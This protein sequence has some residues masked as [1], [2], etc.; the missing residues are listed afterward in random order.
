MRRLAL[1]V[2][3]LPA[4]VLVVFQ[5]CTTREIVAVR[6]GGMG[7]QPATATVY[8]GD[9]VQLSATVQDEHGEELRNAEPAWSSALED[10]VAVTQTGVAHGV[11][12]GISDVSAT[13]GGQT[14]TARITVIPAPVYDFQVS[15]TGG[16]TIVTE[17]GGTDAISVVLL[18]QPAANVVLSV[19]S[20]DPTEVQVA[21][22]TLT[23]TPSDW[24]AAQLVTV[25]GVDD[26]LI[27]GD[28]VTGVTFSVDAAQSYPPFAT[29]SP[30]TIAVLTRDDEAAGFSVASTGGSTSASEGGPADTITV[31]LGVQPNSDVRLMVSV[32]DP[33]DAAVAPTSLTFTPGDWSTP[34]KVAFSAV[35][36][37][38]ADGT[39]TRTITVAVASDSDSAFV[40]LSPKT[41]G[42]MTVDNEVAGIS[43]AHTNG[44]TLAT[45]G[46][47]TD[48][49]VVSLTTP[50]AST[51]V[52]DVTVNNPDDA[53]VSPS[54]LTFTA[55]DWSPR[56]LTFIAVDDPDLDGSRAHT[57][58]VTVNASSDAPFRSLGPHTL[59]AT[60]ADNDVASYVV[61]E[62][63]GSTVVD[64]GGGSD[65]FGLVLTSRPSSDVTLRVTSGDT[66]EARVS[67][68]TVTFSPS[69]WNQTR[70]VTVTGVDDALGD[71]NQVSQISITVDPGSNPAFTGLAPRTVSVTTVDN[72][73]IG[74]TISETD[75]TVVNEPGTLSDAVAIRLNA[76][77]LASV[78]LKI[79][80]SDATEVGVSP[81]T[82]TFTPANGAQAQA[83]VVNGVNDVIEDG[84]VVSTVTVSV[85]VALTLDAAYDTVSARTFNVT[86]LDDEV[87]N[88][89]ISE[90]GGSTA[91]DETGT[92]DIFTVLLSAQP[93]SDVLV[94]VTSEDLGEAVVD[95]ATLTFTPANWST[96][97]TVTV[98]GVDDGVP[99][100]TQVVGVRLSVVDASSDDA[101]DAVADRVVAVTVTEA[102]SGFTVTETGGSTSVYESG[103]SDQF[104][105][106]LDGAPGSPVVLTVTSSDPGEAT[107]DSVTLTFTAANWSTP[108]TVTVR[109][110][111]DTV[112]DGAQ[113]SAVTVAV[114]PSSDPEY[115]GLAPRVVSVTTGD[116]EVP[117]FQVV[118]T[119]GVTTVDERGTTD[120]FTV[121]LGVEPRSTVVLGVSVGD[122]TEVAVDSA[123]LT[124]TPANWNVAR[125][126]T[127]TGLPDGVADGDQVSQIT[128]SILDAISDDLWDPLPNQT[129]TVTNLD[130]TAGFTVTQTGG[131]T[132]VSESGT[133]DQFSVVLDQAPLSNVVFNVTSGDATEVAVD[134]ATLTFTPTTW[135]TPKT[136]T[137][138]GVDDPTVDGTQVTGVTVAVA[139]GSDPTFVGLSPKQVSVTTTDDDVAG[140]S[141]TQTGGTTSVD[142]TG[143]TDVF[144][145]VLTRQPLSNVTFTVTSADV[146]EAVVDAATLTFTP[147]TWST[148][149]TVVVTGVDDQVADGPQL[150]DVTVAVGAGS[151]AAFLGLASQTVSV[152]TTDDEIADF[153]VTQT[154]GSTSVT[155]GGSSDTFTVVLLSR[156]ASSVTITA[157]SPNPG[158]VTVSPSSVSFPPGQWNSPRTFTVTAVNDAVADGNQV[159]LVVVSVDDATSNDL[160]DAA[161]DK[162]V[163][164]TSVDDEVA[165]FTIVESGGQT[166]VSESGTTD[167]FTVALTA[168]PVSP[169]TLTITSGDTGEVSV[170]TTSVSFTSSDW[171]TPKTVTVQGV[172]DGA[173]DGSQLTD[174][175]IAVGPGAYPVYAA[176]SP[177]NVV[178]T[179]TDVN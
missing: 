117:S 10:I 79:T 69:T 85:D 20:A 93:L 174:V 19:A 131:S 7:I 109:G 168:Q 76:V 44:Y 39:R 68:A 26:A 72:D 139:A 31:V 155:E 173:P 119:G 159:T 1:F 27:D 116:N 22:P 179:T 111:D 12:S 38:V 28:Q 107:V 84:D 48:S 176:V 42:A 75:G 49:I 97:K 156:P 148:A 9:S 95:S 138:T 8:V 136:V 78:V 169:V 150:T 58:T 64:E 37:S 53:I 30:R 163:S 160:F 99:D 5:A 142:E 50:P 140:F 71:G 145:V 124:F 175:T 88:L 96:A 81:T 115:V 114:D 101:W 59:D 147:A 105:V 108:K 134:S 62:S 67:P 17:A 33:A 89:I 87:P 41:I 133:A 52:L 144:T 40:G 126:V 57:I 130:V 25:L 66:T 11:R 177:Q 167:S 128:L 143:T 106:V 118:Q 55:A 110:V 170:V 14:A 158:E 54:S 125:T 94:A 77:P 73:G 153:A 104:T 162:T 70:T 122:P 135:S 3:L 164:V 154:G 151:D 178:V 171:S 21:A 86:T 34:R 61:T 129:V 29:A 18:T 90:T 32:D 127:V 149:K 15:E 92:T 146:G 103:T 56:R 43:L 74:F 35:D 91:V 46:G 47:A 113:V 83:V 121:V 120:S 4:S 123:T 165:G 172:A 102:L 2:A 100:G 166:T 80:P 152:Q 161:P 60:T 132:T 141:V 112:A 23:F 157:T 16:S 45:E 98:R 24:N 51:V 65:T 36:D 82:L 63:G 6:V 137:V 13:F